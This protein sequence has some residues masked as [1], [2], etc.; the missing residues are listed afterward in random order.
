MPVGNI[1]FRRL[2]FVLLGVGI[3]C[4]LGFLYKD[5]FLWMK[6]A[7]FGYAPDRFG[8][9]V[10]VIFLC[11][12]FLRLKRQTA[13]P[14]QPDLK[15]LAL[16]LLSLGIFFIGYVA[17][18]HFIQA[19]SLVLIGFGITVYWGGIRL[20]RTFLFP[21]AFLI[22]MVPSV[23][24]LLESFLGVRLRQVIATVSGL[25]LN[26]TGGLWNIGNGVL[27]LKDIELPVQYLRNSLSS[28]LALLILTCVVAEIMFSKNWQKFVFASLFGV[29][30][31]AAHSVFIASM[32]WSFEY[33]HD[34]LDEGLWENRGWV[35]ALIFTILL[36]AVGAMVKLLGSKRRISHSESLSQPDESAA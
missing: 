15:G 31:V 3:L 13:G 27:H 4:E 30:F 2:T 19:V 35:P 1:L 9:S 36:A 8:A 32:G 12:A 17:D 16:V 23:S 5:I 11:I 18:I 33:G 22:L 21:F 34:K 14:F 24:F 26:M 10:P 6:N 29:L 28:P 7:W 20:G 25:I